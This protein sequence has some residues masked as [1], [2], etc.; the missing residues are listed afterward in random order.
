MN[1]ALSKKTIWILEDDFNCQFVYRDVLSSCYEI[2]FYD[3]LSSLEDEIKNQT[4]DALI[5]DLQLPD[6]HFLNFFKKHSALEFRHLPILVISSS[7]DLD[8][9]RFF[10][11]AGIFDYLVKPF[12]SSELRAK[13]ERLLDT[14]RI[15]QRRNSNSLVDI[16]LF[17]GTV[18]HANLQAS[19]LTHKEIFILNLLNESPMQGCSREM[20]IRT[21]WQ[22]AKVGQKTFDVH[23]HNLRR[24]INPLGLA[25]RCSSPHQYSLVSGSGGPSLFSEAD[26]PDRL[27]EAAGS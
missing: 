20:I 1:P 23:L 6:G 5:A 7:D 8:I 14:P 9:M 18:T 19:D 17:R 15:S 26:A 25:I 21:V 3:R 16:D 12:N 4:P 11:L 13:I 2:H 27:P 22:T 24:K 10:F